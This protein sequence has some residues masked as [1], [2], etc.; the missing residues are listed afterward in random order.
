MVHTHLARGQ[1]TKW[2]LE[3]R[4]IR[5]I[6]DVIV[7]FFFAMLKEFLSQETSKLQRAYTPW[8]IL[9][10]KEVLATITQTAK[11]QNHRY[12]YTTKEKIF[13]LLICCT[14]TVLVSVLTLLVAS[15][16]Y[17]PKS[18]S[19]FISTST[20]VFN[21]FS[22][23]ITLPLGF[24]QDKVGVGEPSALQVNFTVCPIQE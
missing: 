8:C 18:W 5:F 6:N 21:S 13:H 7:V 1:T 23:R 3:R 14:S 11:S 2:V 12:L 22:C 10:M 17:L 9:K 4:E 20:V 15:H 24:F 16:V 19:L